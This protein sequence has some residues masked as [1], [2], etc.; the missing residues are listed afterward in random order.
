[1]IPL[2]SYSQLINDQ[3][4]LP[5]PSYILRNKFPFE[6]TDGQSK[7]I[8]FLDDF[9]EKDSQHN[10]MVIR[11]YA[12]TGKTTLMGGLV[13]ILPL[14]NQNFVLLAPTGRAAKVLSNYSKHTAFTIHKK[15]YKSVIGKEDNGP[16]FK[17]LKNYHKDTIFIVDE[18]SMIPVQKDHNGRS[19]LNDLIQYISEKEGN[20]IILIGDVAQL[21][22]VKQDESYALDSTFLS[23]SYNL[24]VASFELTEITRQALDS[25]I[26]QNATQLRAQLNKDPIKIQFRTLEYKD[27]YKMTS[28]RL[29]DGLRYAYDK[30]GIE[31]TLIIC[32][33]N[34]SAVQYNKFIRHQLLF[35]EEELEAGDLLMIA[36]NNYLFL[37]DDIPSGFLAN[38]D[39]VE[40]LKIK[41]TEENYG[42]RFADLELKLVDYSHKE[43]FEAKVVLDTL[44]S[45]SPSMPQ[46]MN[47]E[48]YNQVLAD[49][50]G[51]TK[52]EQREEMKKDP[53]LNALQI[54]Y[55]YA[56]TCH[57]SQGGQWNAIF[58]DQGYLVKEGINKEFLRWLY[59]AVTRAT[60]ELFLLNF[61]SDFF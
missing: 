51:L 61:H 19:L 45:N 60:D 10:A 8:D 31:N 40:V 25:G 54:K 16:Q 35:R 4:S 11:G 13:N 37:P 15:I 7:I 36:R 50:A 39:F 1:L 28:D 23:D 57:K 20:K 42:L 17:C 30:F 27:I 21:P 6:P 53:F 5:K 48:I 52:K 49:Y 46:E 59:T 22:P 33:S 34:R 24:N 43:S 12:G 58:V 38:G 41:N 18:A 3:F 47:R 26:L 2:L 44:H 32:R 56:L 29:E 9:L 14:F 55:A